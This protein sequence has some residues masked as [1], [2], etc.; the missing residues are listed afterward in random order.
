MVKIRVEFN[1]MPLEMA[2]ST[3]RSAAAKLRSLQSFVE[4]MKSLSLRCDGAEVEIVNLAQDAD[5]IPRGEESRWE[6]HVYFDGK[7]VFDRMPGAA[8]MHESIAKSGVRSKVYKPAKE[9]RLRIVVYYNSFPVRLGGCMGPVYPELSMSPKWAVERWQEAFYEAASDFDE[10]SLEVADISLMRYSDIPDFAQ[11]IK[12]LIV[13]AFNGKPVFHPDRDS[14][15]PGK[16]EL[17]KEI[18]RWLNER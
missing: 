15:M 5:K 9:P 2:S 14:K 12:S 16:Q 13:V 7:L 17:Q 1:P 3:D 10:V 4:F 18:E 6:P 8:E 11:S